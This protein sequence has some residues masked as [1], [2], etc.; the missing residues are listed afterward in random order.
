MMTRSNRRESFGIHLGQVARLWRAEIDR[1]L[2]PHGL[3]EAQWLT[4]L[5]LS[6][7]TEPATQ[8]R[9]AAAAGVQEPTMVRMLDRLE[10]EGLVTRSP[11]EGDRRAKS[12]CLTGKAA[13]GLKRIRKVTETLREALLADI[14]DA[15]IDTCLRVLG[16]LADKLHG[17]TPGERRAEK[18]GKKAT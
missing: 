2:S 11:I 4:L 10:A 13:P 9:L 5:H 1:R 14:D 18:N 12:V 17:A 16:R 3:T 8:K 15:D 6:R 7:L